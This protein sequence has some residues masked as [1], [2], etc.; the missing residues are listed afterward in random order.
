[1]S[2]PADSL[3]EY[4]GAQCRRVDEAL[5]RFLPGPPACPLPLSEAM[6]YS[7][8]AGGKRFRPVLVLAAAA[9]RFTWSTA[10]GGLFSAA[11]AC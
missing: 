7:L 3:G 2:A 1:V 11:T 5:A 6:R 10:K 9:R 4:V 8:F